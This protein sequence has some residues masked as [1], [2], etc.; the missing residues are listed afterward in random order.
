[1]FD[2]LYT[3]NGEV[4][5]SINFEKLENDLRNVGKEMAKQYLANGIVKEKISGIHKIFHQP[6]LTICFVYFPENKNNEVIK[7]LVS[8]GTYLARRLQETEKRA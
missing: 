6:N 1:M 3:F 5:K 7:C 4:D 2:L 8:Y